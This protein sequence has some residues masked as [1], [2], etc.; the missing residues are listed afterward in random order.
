MANGINPKARG[1][2]VTNGKQ[3]ESFVASTSQAIAMTR[4]KRSVWDITLEPF[5]GAHFATAPTALVEPCILAGTSARGVCPDCGAPWERIVSRGTAVTSGGGRRKHADVK[6]DQGE[7]GAMATGVWY[8]VNSTGFRPL[9][10]CYDDRYRAEHPRSGNA[11]K[12]AQRD[13]WGD[14]WRRVRRRPGKDYWPTKPAVVLDPFFGAGTT[15]L[16][17]DDHGRDCIGIELNPAYAK[18]AARRLRANLNKVK[19][20]EQPTPGDLPL[21]APLAAPTERSP[22]PRP[23]AGD[24]ETPTGDA[25]EPPSPVGAPIEGVP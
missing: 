17:A 1:S 6:E 11:R 20:V 2:R 22:D 18:I 10:R 21:F 24:G 7:N 23:S 16:V 13:A 9:C 14:W 4:N 15:G 8:S 3:N 25:L 12:R 5:A 19:G